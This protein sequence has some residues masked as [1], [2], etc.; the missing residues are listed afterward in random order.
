MCGMNRKQRRASARLGPTSN[1]PA[2]TAAQLLEAGLSHH[3]AGRLVEAEACYRRVPG[4]PPDQADALHL[5]GVIATQV[6][7]S[8]LAVEL[9]GRAIEQN[10]RNPAYFSN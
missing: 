6:S 3:R 10:E 2:G 5:L 9:I 8:D 1:P 7:R 4:T